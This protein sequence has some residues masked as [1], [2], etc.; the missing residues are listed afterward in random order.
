MSIYGGMFSGVS[1][2][3][4]QSSAF[5]IISDNIANVNTVG[6]KDTSTRFET[7]VTQSASRTRYSPG[8]VLSRPFMNPEKQGLLQG[9]SS[10]TDIAVVG[11]GFFVVNGSSSPQIDDQYLYTRAG[12]FVADA[13]GNLVNTAGYYLQGWATDQDGVINNATTQDLLTSLDTVS[14]SGFSSIANETQNMTLAANL[15][16]SASIGASETTNLTIFDSLGVDHLFTINW[17]KLSLNAWTYTIDLTN[18]GGNTNQLAPATGSIRF[19][20]DG[21]LLQVDGVAGTTGAT[22]TSNYSIGGLGSGTDFFSSGAATNT[23]SIDWG[24]FGQSTGLSQFADDYNASLLNQ[25]GSGPSA[26]TEVEID[27]SGLVTAIFA[28]GESRAIYQLAVATV[29][30]PSEMDSASGNAFTASATSGDIVL[31][32]PGSSGS[33]SIQSSALESSTVDL[34]AEF[35]DL[36]ITQRA[37]SASTKLIT[38]GDEMLDE[39]IRV[40][41]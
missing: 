29:P 16:A 25:D 4:A 40:K 9:T 3:N 21:T 34:S 13:D 10:S 28:N 32:V 7:L 36:I 2:L 18:N 37:Y 39:I 14:L 41:R 24:I 23:I 8:G 20:T 19:G 5:G 30:A 6:Y 35:T 11:S 12:S 38:T 17:T 1:A 15:P 27:A 22:G 33:G 31:S 26:L